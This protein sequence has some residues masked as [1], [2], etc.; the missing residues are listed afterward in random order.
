M[1]EQLK[2]QGEQNKEEKEAKPEFR[3]NLTKGSFSLLLQGTQECVRPQ[4][5]PESKSWV[6]MLMHWSVRVRVMP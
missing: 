4:R 2:D 1:T 5:W 6:F 3:Q